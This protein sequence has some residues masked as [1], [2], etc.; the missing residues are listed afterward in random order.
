MAEK[1]DSSQTVTIEE[2]ALSNAFQLE[3]LINVLEKKG[4]LNKEEILDE[5][6]QVKKQ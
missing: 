6:K 2:L 4:V 1:L 5:L 3:A